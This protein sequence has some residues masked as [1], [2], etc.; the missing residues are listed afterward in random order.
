MR[1]RES[2]FAAVEAC[3]GAIGWRIFK[4][5]RMAPSYRRQV[6][7]RQAMGTGAACPRSAMWRT[8]CRLER[9]SGTG[10]PW[11]YPGP[12]GS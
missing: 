11:P 10:G 7:G 9:R 2:L 1:P 4:R 8:Q 5:S 6:Y 3:K 12:E